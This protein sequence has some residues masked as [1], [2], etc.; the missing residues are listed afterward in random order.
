MT[1]RLLTSFGYIPVDSYTCIRADHGTK[2]AACAI[3]FRVKENDRTVTFAIKFICHFKDIFGT[4]IS[5]KLTPLAPLHVD[6]NT[7]SSHI[8]PPVWIRISQ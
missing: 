7:T 4:S 2:G 5:A 1:A 8:Y 6:N 3:V